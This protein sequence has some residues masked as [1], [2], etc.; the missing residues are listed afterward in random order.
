MLFCGPDCDS[1]FYPLLG[2]H[3]L[4]SFPP[5]FLIFLSVKWKYST[6]YFRDLLERWHKVM[7]RRCWVYWIQFSSVAQLCLTLCDPMDCSVPGFPAYYQLPKLAQTHVHQGSDA[8]QPSHPL[9]SPSPPAFNLSQHQSL[10]QGVGSSH[11]V[12]KV[13][14]FQL[15]HQSWQWIFRTDFL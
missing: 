11:Q 2:E 10:F 3:G 13:L 12:A 14:E 5:L 7:H 6:I 1:L 8:V 4:V 15:Q 9:S